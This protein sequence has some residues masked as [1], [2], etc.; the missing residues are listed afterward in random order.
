M[1]DRLEIAAWSYSQ[2]VYIDVAG[3]I[4]QV[5][6]L[7]EQ[8]VWLSS[9]IRSSPFAGIA[10]CLPCI[11][12]DNLN[13]DDLDGLNKHRPVGEESTIAKIKFAFEEGRAEPYSEGRCWHNLFRNPVIVRGFPIMERDPNLPGLEIP[14]HIMGALIQTKCAYA[15]NRTMILKGF[16]SMLV[17][18]DQTN[19]M[20]LWH[21]IFHTDKTRITYAERGLSTLQISNFSKLQSNRH[22]VGW[23]AHARILA[24]TRDPTFTSKV[25]NAAG[26]SEPVPYKVAR[27]GLPRV[28]SGCL[29]EKISLTAGKYINVGATFAMGVKDR[30]RH[31]PRKAYLSKLNELRYKFFVFWD[32]ASKRGWLLNGLDGL[33][34][35]LLS[36][37]KH[38]E[39][40]KAMGQVLISKSEDILEPQEGS[41]TYAFDVLRNEKNMK[42]PVI[43]DKDELETDSDDPNLWKR[44]KS[45]VHL[46]D[47]VEQL[48]NMLE[49]LID[50]QVEKAGQSGVEVKKYARRRLEGWDFKD[51]VSDNDPIYPLV[52]T[53]EPIGK[54]WVDLAR[55]IGAV[56][57]FGKDFGDMIE[58]S[59][60][61][62]CTHW[63]QLPKGKYYLAAHVSDLQEIIEAKN[64]DIMAVP[65]R[66]CDGISWS[67]PMSTTKVCDCSPS[68]TTSPCDP[69][70]VLWPV[71]L[72]S[73]LPL[74]KRVPLHTEGAVIFGHNARF[75]WKWRDHGDPVPTTD[76]IPELEADH[77]TTT[78]SSRISGSGE[79]QSTAATSLYT[80]TTD[81]SP[82]NISP[83]L[84]RVPP[85]EG[86]HR[87][88]SIRTMQS[89]PATG[90]KK[91]AFAKRLRN[92]FLK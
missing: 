10:T 23:C 72:T 28:G 62:N 50:H 66:L 48:Y 59:S 69:V 63:R 6:E 27:S 18:V 86:D 17:P 87:T 46:E 45:F 34:H 33:L 38:Y 52:E 39:R 25:D 22:I 44:K 24:G 14:L 85:Q 2:N 43:P 21:H 84:Q 56:T 68:S 60:E 89:A 70:Q 3:S 41:N 29:L 40:D 55:S 67:S 49:I 51:L 20:T 71:R 53:I 47:W 82:D 8:L 90:H 1:N 31:L 74:S 73:R 26:R 30:P 37:L 16:S 92:K 5:L 79:D 88:D 54:G 75:K 36:M 78:A 9:A 58:P 57:L 81:Q 91:P 32:T 83:D 15:F 76:N 19:G 77:L 61:V 64:G 11:R 35:L 4:N 42:L 80:Q 12:I 7:G 65:R 13:P